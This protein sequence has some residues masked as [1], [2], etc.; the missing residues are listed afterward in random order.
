MY[1]VITSTKL[2]IRPQFTQSE[3]DY[4]L[5]C[6]LFI[7]SHFIDTV[8]MLQPEEQIFRL[9]KRIKELIA[10]YEKSEC[11]FVPRTRTVSKERSVTYETAQLL[12]KTSSWIAI[13]NA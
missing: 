3:F 5:I 1:V 7:D 2:K 9:N 12:L 13:M 10:I 6:H 4:G 11:S 8:R